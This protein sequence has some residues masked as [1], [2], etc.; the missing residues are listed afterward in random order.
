MGVSCW[1]FNLLRCS[2]FINAYLNL[3]HFHSC[4]MLCPFYFIF[5]FDSQISQEIVRFGELP[6]N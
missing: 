5:F 3:L 6:K 2:A 1:V 4:L